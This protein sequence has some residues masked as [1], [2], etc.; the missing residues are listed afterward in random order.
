MINPDVTSAYKLGIDEKFSETKWPH[1][2][3]VAL[4]ELFV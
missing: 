3:P 1:V 4:I 2:I